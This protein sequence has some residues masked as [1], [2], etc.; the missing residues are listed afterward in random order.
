MQANLPR[1]IYWG[2]MNLTPYLGDLV[3]DV[4]D[5]TGRP[6]DRAGRGVDG[7]AGVCGQIHPRVG[8]LDVDGFGLGGVP[9]SATQIINE[10]D[11]LSLTPYL[12]L[13]L[14]LTPFSYTRKNFHKLIRKKS[15]Y[16]VRRAV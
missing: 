8:H 12:G 15:S 10:P 6:R 2:K 1:T 4:A 3:G 16:I 13:K 14:S 7:Q 11:P 5:G 9:S